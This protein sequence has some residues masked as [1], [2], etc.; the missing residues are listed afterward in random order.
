MEWIIF[1]LTQRRLGLLAGN[2]DQRSFTTNM[3]FIL[4]DKTMS[5]SK[6]NIIEKTL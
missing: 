6:G 2:P 1:I 5:I 4:S 3:H